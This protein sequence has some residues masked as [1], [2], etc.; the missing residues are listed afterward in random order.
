MSKE[1]PKDLKKITVTVIIVAI[2]IFLLF[3]RIYSFKDGG[4]VVYASFG[5]GLL[6]SVEQRH[7]LY[8]EAGYAYYEIGTVI[9]IFGIEV[10]NNA[11]VDY[12]HGHSL[13]HSPE[14]EA[15]NKEI[16]KVLNEA[17]QTY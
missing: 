15:A 17:L 10:Y 7:R 9:T 8:D 5:F 12:E 16:D 3:P 2:A 11:H 6:Y 4:T 13:E 14:V 1:K